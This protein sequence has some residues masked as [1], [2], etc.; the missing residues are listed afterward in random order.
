MIKVMSLMKR[1]EG[2]P[3]AEF[4]AWLLDE[5]VA[6]ARNLPG[7]RKYTANALVS[8]NP[9]APYDGDHRA[10]LRQ[11]GGDGG[12][13]R[14]RRRQGGGRRRGGAL[15]EPLP[16][17]LRGEAAVLM[18]SPLDQDALEAALA[19]AGYFADE[20]L[21]TALYLAL[22]LGKPLLLEGMP[23]VGKTEVGNVL[24]RILGRDCIRLQCYEGID[25]SRALYDW[26]HVRQLLHVR[27]AEKAGGVETAELYAPEF[28]VEMPLLKA[29]RNAGSA[30]LLIDEIDR[31]D[32][33]FEAFLL[34]F[35]SDFQISIPEIGTVKAP[36]PV[37]TI[38][39]SNRTRELHDAL[40]RRCLYHWIDYPDPARERAIVERHAPGIAAE[41]AERLVGGG[42]GGAA[43]AAGQA[44]GDRRERRLGARR[45]GAGARRRGLAGGAAALAGAAG[46]GPGGPGDGRAGRGGMRPAEALLAGFPGA[47]RAAGLPVDP[48]RGADFLRAVRCARLR[49]AADLARVGRVT[50]TGSREE[51]PLF[52]SGVCGL[53][54]RPRGVRRGRAR[55][56]DRG[57]AA[58]PAGARRAGAGGRAGR[59]RGGRPRRTRWRGRR[60]SGAAGEAERRALAGLRREFARLPEVARRRWVP[61]PAGRLDLARTGRAARRTFGETLRLLRQARQVRPRRMLLLVD[62]SGSM[63]AQSETVLRFAQAL[64]R[65]RS[66]VETFTF[67]TRLTRVTAALGRRDG[68]A[69][70]ARL[71]A[72]VSD[73][74]G[75]TRIGEA[76]ETFLGTLTNAGLARGAVVLVVSDGLERGDPGAMVAAVRRLARLAHRL[77]WVSPLAAD[78]RYRPVTRAMAGVLPELDALVDGG[79]PRGAGAAAG[80]DRGGGAAAAARGVAGVQGGGGMTGIVDGHHHIWRQADLPWLQGPIVPR[81]FGPYEPIRRDYPI[82]EYL[83][84][85][86]GSGVEKSVYVQTQLG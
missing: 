71:A 39:T 12:G 66:R 7:L 74:D 17:G 80:A 77:V 60:R 32:D 50:L 34:E 52:D 81:I 26:D 51:F 36:Q 73:F 18:A 33:A 72:E 70:L 45:D 30:I 76:L 85:L 53:V 44:A 35:L 40:R 78:P 6:F 47:L 25:A 64:T 20:G 75:G 61:A 2:M 69:A 10:L 1:K 48:A 49:E 82:E 42:G 13:V 38:L 68:E 9:D 67:G 84:D 23:G 46:E 15:L 22:E 31:A 8:E 11:R 54:R 37:V 83:A 19:E 16:H 79:Q 43:A 28:L 14:H 62:V 27:V 65:A 5:H 56:G 55:G 4:K 57:A 24:A 29:L 86:A 3:F 59:R 41:A 58:R 63:K 21:V